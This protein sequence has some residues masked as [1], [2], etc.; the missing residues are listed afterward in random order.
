MCMHVGPSEPQ[1]MCGGPRTTFRAISLLPCG[2]QGSNTEAEGGQ[3]PVP[4][5]PP[6]WSLNFYINFVILSVYMH[7]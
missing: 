1:H 2:L 4:S 6:H 3:T 7:T 5:E